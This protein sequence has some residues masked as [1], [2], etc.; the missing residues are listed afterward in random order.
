MANIP[1]SSLPE[2]QSVASSDY[3]AIDNGTD[4]KKI[5]VDKFN[6]EATGSA[7]Q[8]MQRAETAATN[9]A[10]SAADALVSKNETSNLITG[11]QTL[12]SD[13]QTYAADAQTSANAAS[14]SATT[15]SNKATQA[16]NSAEQ[17][18]TY[19]ENVNSY[20]TEAKSW[21]RGGTGSRVGEETDNAMYYANEAHSS[22][23]NAASSEAN[24]S[25]SETNAAT[26]ETNAAS[27]ATT[28]A[29]AAAAA[30]VSESNAAT[31]A[32]NAASSETNAAASDS[33]AA[34]SKAAA[35]LSEAAA[36]LSK[37]DAEAWAVGTRNG[38][39]V[40]SS[41]PTYQN[42][43][44]YWA[45]VAAGAAGGG[46]T[47]FNGRSGIVIAAQHDYSAGQV[48]FDNSNNNFVATN[49]QAAIE[50]V[51]GNVGNVA[52]DLSDLDSSLATVA[53]TGSYS[54]L[55]NTPTIPT[56]V[57]DLT[58][59]SHFVVDNPSFTEAVTRTNIVSG[60][61]F[62]IILGKIA[63]FFTDLKAVAFSGA[64]SDLSGTPTL[65]T[66]ATSGSYNDLSNKPTIQTIAIEYNGTASATGVRNQR[67]GINGVYT[68]IDGS[69]YMEQTKTLSTS[70]DTTFTFTNSAITANSVIQP[71]ASIFGIVPSN[72]TTSAGSC[73]VTIPKHDSAVS[74]KVRI[75]IR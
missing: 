61:A 24:A 42:N 4:S 31:S 71:Y 15:A 35:A 14:G 75:Y 46:V 1:I 25:A 63:K 19:A 74:L 55:S 60:E 47:S 57:S 9:A 45:E 23:L 16:T 8:Y 34:L 62:S 5:R 68:A 69:K 2:A 12:V 3:L 52:T 28:A 17:A 22:E 30:A 66:V 7:Y 29:N 58:N 32:T 26:S 6:E 70:A 18:R 48:D 39:P 27:S 36:A 50:E 72:I 67:L 10:A 53:K 40:S 20:A 64:Y 21:A 13:A 56:K 38:V 44:K 73:V 11:A 33:A 37:E 54:D 41:D 51:Q 49:T 65:A 59:D 43:A